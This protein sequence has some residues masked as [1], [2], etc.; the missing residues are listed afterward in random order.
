LRRL[1][2]LLASAACLTLL[3]CTAGCEKTTE[4][5]PP[6]F[7]LTFDSQ[8][9]TSLSQGFEV[10]FRVDT[11]AYNNGDTIQLGLTLHSTRPCPGGP[12]ITIRYYTEQ[13]YDFVVTN[14]EGRTV[15]RWSDGRTFAPVTQSETLFACDSIGYEAEWN[16]R[17]STG[18]E[19]ERGKAYT[20]TAYPKCC[21][22]A[23]LAPPA[24]TFHTAGSSMAA[25]NN[26]SALPTRRYRL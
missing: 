8:E 16:M 5:R 13:R 15:W 18:A 6:A 17:D 3:L 22:S 25:A 23:I 11:L 2:G 7:D 10:L 26:Q 9:F 19:L 12:S 14:S 21:S 20:L 24:L 4:S 1:H